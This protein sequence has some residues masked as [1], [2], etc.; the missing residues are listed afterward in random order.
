MIGI[1]EAGYGPNL[2]PLAQA[3]VAWFL[4]ETDL[5]GWEHFRATVCRASDPA[6]GRMVIDDSK[7]VYGGTH[8]F[9]QFQSAVLQLLPGES[10]F[11]S[12]VQSYL[13]SEC[14]TS[15]LEEYC[16]QDSLI[17]TVETL[18]KITLPIVKARL[19]FPTEWNQTVCQSGSKASVL[20]DGFVELVSA[21]MR[22]LPDSEPIH[23][24]ADKHGGRNFYGPLLQRTFPDGWPRALRESALESRYQIDALRRP[25]SVVFQPRADSASICVAFASMVAKWLREACM[26]QF[27]QFW[28]THLPNLPPTAGYPVDARR[29]FAA[30]EPI[31]AKL[32]IA[33]SR[34]WRDK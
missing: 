32:G 15:F 27:N 6:A 4:P 22:E 33:K 28:Q 26:V 29:Y 19:I 8:R 12:R 21:I 34:I 7:L 17:P 25:V 9:I 31:A 1:D 24:I 5:G 3:A 2:G 14:H 10:S 23:I 30:I 13:I 20:A 11:K 18:Q 16:L